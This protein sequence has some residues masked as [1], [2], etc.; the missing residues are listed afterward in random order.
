MPEL[1]LSFS[2]AGTPLLDRRINRLALNL[3][4]FTEPLRE[5]GEVI[6]DNIRAQF[7]AQGKPKWAALSD[8]YAARK[9]RKHPGKTILR[10]TDRL[11]QSLT[12]RTAPGAIYELTP[13]HVRIGTDVQTPDSRWN[14]GLIHQLGAPN[15]NIPARPMIRLTMGSRTRIVVVFRQWLERKAATADLTLT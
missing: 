10:A 5:T 2:V 13:T 12:E 8:L 11:M 15:R 14:L 3:H 9:A 7:A 1:R 6:Y 4:D